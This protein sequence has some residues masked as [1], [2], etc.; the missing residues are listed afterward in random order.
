MSSGEVLLCVSV[1]LALSATNPPPFPEQV[2]APRP[3]TDA[4][5]AEARASRESALLK[6]KADD[7]RVMCN[8]QFIP[9]EMDFGEVLAGSFEWRLVRFVNLGDEPVRMTRGAARGSTFEFPY[10]RDEIATNQLGE[11]LVGFKVPDRQGATLNKQATFFFE[12]G[13]APA[14]K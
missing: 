14:A 13:R 9:P 7:D 11:A 6:A 8:I 5:L 10:T 4:E 1:A 12:I 3:A 2:G